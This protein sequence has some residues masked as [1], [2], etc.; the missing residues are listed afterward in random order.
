M[1]I[2]KY[3]SRDSFAAIQHTL[4]KNFLPSDTWGVIEVPAA[5]EQA[6]KD[7]SAAILSDEAAAQQAEHER[8]C[9]RFPEKYGHT[10]PAGSGKAL[11]AVFPSAAGTRILFV[12]NY[13]QRPIKKIFTSKTMGTGMKIHTGKILNRFEPDSWKKESWFFVAYAL[14]TGKENDFAAVSRYSR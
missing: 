6:E 13:A 14:N 11:Y 4:Q 10:V 5:P 9:Q 12:T 2:H 1:R 7:F 8:L 3:T